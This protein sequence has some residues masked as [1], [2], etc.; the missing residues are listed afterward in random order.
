MATERVELPE[1]IE[2]VEAHV[3]A[4]TQ[5]MSE[6]FAGVDRRFDRVDG[7]V[8]AM[9]TRFNRMERKIDRILHHLAGHRS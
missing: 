9:D 5:S 6:E 4:L 2:R 1:Y 3:D 7:R 8:E